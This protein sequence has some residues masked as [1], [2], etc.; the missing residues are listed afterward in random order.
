MKIMKILF[1]I[2][3]LIINSKASNYDKELILL[4]RNLSSFSYDLHAMPS[5]GNYRKRH[6]LKHFVGKK[7]PLP[8]YVGEGPY[9]RRN[10][11]AIVDIVT[12]PNNWEVCEATDEFPEGNINHKIGLW[13]EKWKLFMVFG[14]VSK[15]IKGQAAG[16]LVSA[17]VEK[18]GKRKLRCDWTKN[19][20]NE[21]EL[22][23]SSLKERV[24]NNLELTEYAQPIALGATVAGIM[25]VSEKLLEFLAYIALGSI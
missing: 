21:F 12:S 9:G 15:P 25:V 18:N 13:N 22:L 6:T 20:S 16:V 14:Y 11:A 8:V 24:S 4:H 7:K 5:S 23:R 1:I 2:M 19:N 3:L 17:Y 10:S